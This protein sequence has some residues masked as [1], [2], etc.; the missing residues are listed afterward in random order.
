M[1]LL[2]I[3]IS[4]S[5][6]A[7]LCSI[8]MLTD[9]MAAEQLFKASD[10]TKPALAFNGDYAVGVRTVTGTHQGQ[11]NTVDFT[12]KKD[13]QLTLE[14][15]YPS[16]IKNSEVLATYD[17]QTRTGKAFSLQGEAFR[18]APFDKSLGKFPLVVLSH[19]YTGYRS[20]MF[21]LGEHLASHGYV[22]V[23]IDHTDSTNADVDFS[24]NNLS[25]GFPS[26]L[27][28]R[29][30][31][32]QF[33]LDYMS[34]SK[35][36]DISDTKL[37]SI[38]G[39]SMGGYG[40]INTAGGCYDFSTEKLQK[41]GFRDGNEAIIAEQLNYCMGGSSFIDSRW[42]A[43]I[44]FAPWGGIQ[45]VF[46]A[47]SLSKIKI[48]SLFVGGELD[49]IS[50][51]DNGVKKLYSEIAAR[52]KYLM[53]YENAHHNIAPHPAPEVALQ[54]VE[55]DSGHYVEPNWNSETITRINEH[56]VLAF[57]NCHIKSDKASCKY[58]PKRISS[59]Q[60]IK[61]NGKLEKPWPGFP[62]KWGSGVRFIQG[63]P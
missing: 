20:I 41:L 46:K 39:Y 18:D 11:I 47:R 56:M 54:G 31:D 61:K 29:A 55:F 50:G 5:I 52:K 10:N 23:A 3:V 13:R 44:A 15:W 19:G 4:K 9:G 35:F 57:L 48:P 8:I 34:V 26:T 40:A 27:Y 12:S 38:V 25:S 7:W 53:I 58:L 45:E 60:T 6:L 33:T 59:T 22:V 42:K 30:R 62:I 28:H 63:N 1:K 32:Q 24:K 17:N 43:L 14:I 2:K 51:F 16:T 49:S 36:A 21:Y 37:A